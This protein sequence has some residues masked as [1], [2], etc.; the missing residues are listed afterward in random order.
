[1]KYV[2]WF[3]LVQG[4]LALRAGQPAAA[5]VELGQAL[6]LARRIGFPTLTWQAAHRLAEAHA[7]G[8]R[9]A[10]AASA[11][12]L[13]AET[14]ERM[15]ADASL[16]GRHRHDGLAPRNSAIGPTPNRFRGRVGRPCWIARPQNP[17]CRTGRRQWSWPQ[18]HKSGGGDG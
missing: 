8:G 5:R 3:H 9:L 11:A 7:A 14:I 13:A 16:S 12:I 18:C 17:A 6:D 2:G 4:E 15:A 10:D 1:M